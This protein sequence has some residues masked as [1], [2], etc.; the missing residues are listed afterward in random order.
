MIKDLFTLNN[1]EYKKSDIPQE[2]LPY[3]KNADIF[4]YLSCMG[5]S[6]A[7]YKSSYGTALTFLY[8][9]KD[10]LEE[11]FCDYNNP[12]LENGYLIIGSGPNG[13]LLCVNCSSGMVGY[14][15]HDKL[16]E[17]TYDS[18]EEIYVELPLSIERFIEMVIY[19]KNEY[20]FDG[21]EAEK[22]LN[23]NR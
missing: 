12:C 3:I 1:I 9:I 19:K 20:P 6:I 21:F 15:F 4:N 5:K 18:F 8:S 17:K 14:A 22:Y 13:D 23:N 7:F 11:D 16:W 10:I 2:L